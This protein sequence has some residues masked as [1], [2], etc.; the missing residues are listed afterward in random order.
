MHSR[1]QRRHGSPVVQMRN[2]V[3]LAHSTINPSQ[4]KPF[5]EPRDSSVHSP[6][7][8]A[9]HAVY[10]PK[11]ARG[12]PCMSV[13][14]VS[15]EKMSC[16]GKTEGLHIRVNSTSTSSSSSSSS[17]SSPAA[18]LKPSHKS[19]ERVLNGRISSVPPSPLDRR[20]SAS[21]STLDRRPSPSPSSLDRRPS[22]SPSPSP[23]TPDR[24]AGAPPSTLD[25][26]HQNGTKATK[27]Y[28]RISV[29]VFDPNK[30]CG[31]L[32]PESRRPCTRS[33]TCKTHSLTHR[34]AVPGRRKHFDS[35]L[36]EHKGR[37]KEKEKEKEREKVKEKEKE[38]EKD[39][40]PNREPQGGRDTSHSF[41][42]LSHDPLN[43]A[44]TNCRDIKTTSPLKARLSSTYIPRAL[45]GGASCPGS[46]PDVA[47]LC[48]GAEVGGR[49]S[50]DEGEAEVPD[51]SERPDCHYS[52]RHPRPMGCC[53]FGSRLM[54]RG[55]Y[56]FDRR[57]DRM[58]LALHCMVEK[59]VNSLMWRKIPL[60]AESPTPSPGAIPASQSFLSPS[61]TGSY[62]MTPPLLSASSAFVTQS[63]G[64]S[65]VSYSAAFPRGSGGMFS[66]MDSSSLVAPVP[67]LSAMSSQGK[68]P[69]AK[70]SRPPKGHEQPFGAVGG[71][72][73]KPPLTAGAIYTASHRRDNI[74]TPPHN[75]NPSGPAFSSNGR[76][77]F[78]AK[79]EPSARTDLTV[80]HPHP[81]EHTLS[82]HSPLPFSPAERR[83]RKGPTPGGKPS[84]VTKASGLS[85]IYRKGVAG[86]ES[87]HTALPRQPM[88]HH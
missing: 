25:R 86:A 46:G 22:S 26:K 76:P 58:R 63:D 3:S 20:P 55:H 71:K 14:V 42:A 53:A 1:N 83:K 45:G 66:I 75:P 27:P 40:R 51:E 54:G 5:R 16:L 8:R 65:V 47:S 64:I 50:S 44:H 31:V 7:S 21:P 4:S 24:R 80:P 13:P 68:K 9:P 60:A 67:A 12:R 61:P 77:P 43:S 62:G 18:L 74:A 84:K 30:H 38:R 28:K 57:W 85:S 17:S 52:P 36:A 41:P 78:C 32:D 87:P 29:R 81:G 39:P 37:V 6:F 49:L 79:P 23:S 2:K 72:K 82:V 34:R 70:P 35:L 69:R 88:V 56:V 19:Q 11:G 73:K 48:L 59:H 33:L 10:P 15:L